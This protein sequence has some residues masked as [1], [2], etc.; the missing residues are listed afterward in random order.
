MLDIECSDEKLRA[1][2][3]FNRDKTVSIGI[4]NR[5]KEA[6]EITLDTSLFNK[7][8]RV[9]E[10]DANDPPC[11]AFADLQDYTVLLEKD[12]LSFTL[13]P[14]SVTYFTTDYLTKEQSIYAEN[15]ALND[16]IVHWNEVKDKNHCYY[17]VFT[18]DEADFI[19]C[20]DNQIA[21]TVSTYLSGKDMKK[22]IKVISVDRS[23]NM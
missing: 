20:A 13:K 2:G 1:A 22:Y 10:Y 6:T 15:V 4:V 9:Y 21:S 16:G 19:P 8:V 23:G 12:S 18:S 14:D 5:N 11:N 7:A 17:R 3:V